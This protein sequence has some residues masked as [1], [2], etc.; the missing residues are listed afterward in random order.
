MGL[1][2]YTLFDTPLGVCGI[3]WSESVGAVG[4]PPLILFQLPEAD[5]AM[6][7]RGIARNPGACRSDAPPSPI[8]DIMERLRRHLA[9]Q[10][11]DFQD[12]AVDL[13]T[14][15]NFERQVYKAARGIP[16][17]QTRTYGEIAEALGRPGAARAVGQALGRNPIPLIIPCHR[18]V[19]ANGKP[20][21]FSA[22]GGSATK[23]RLL[24]IE[25][26]AAGVAPKALSFHFDAGEPA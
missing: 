13:R 25:R 3:A 14:A 23:M 19:A 15:G 22:A 24:E 18:V 1:L 26:A 8:I 10:V 16:A 5:Q 11:E 6:T 2:T 4:P 17:G 7:E 21:G 20:G 9:G 12:V